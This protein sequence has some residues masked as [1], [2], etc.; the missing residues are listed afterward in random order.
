MTSHRAIAL[1]V[2]ALYALA[3]LLAAAFAA[4]FILGELPCP[5]CLLQRIM[6]ALLAIGPILNIRFGPRASHYA[7]SLLAAVVGATVSTRQVLLHI[8]PGDPGFGTALFGYHYYT[9]ALIGFIAAIVL[10]S[11]V[12]LFDRQFEKDPAAY[13]APSVIAHVAVW[14]VIGLTAANVAST[15][16]ECG[17]KACADDPKVYELL[18]R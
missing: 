8:M 4:Q 16:L 10:L 3:A 12:L 13:S 1:N 5:L 9:W 7:L 6:F 2:L 14:L 17:F 15:L 11:L 18:K